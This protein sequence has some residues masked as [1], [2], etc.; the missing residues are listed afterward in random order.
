MK[1]GPD[2]EM[3]DL[4]IC[5]AIS[6]KIMISNQKQLLQQRMTFP[7]NKNETV[8]NFPGNTEENHVPH[9]PWSR[10]AAT[11]QVIK[12]TKTNCILL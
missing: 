11:A 9:K 4:L 12:E 8:G 2:D 1:C 6:P 5:S 3:P 7:Q 10:Q